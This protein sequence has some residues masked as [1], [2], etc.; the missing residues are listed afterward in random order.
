M[1]EAVVVRER[2]IIFSSEMVCAILDGRK[3]QT[4]RVINNRVYIEFTASEEPDSIV[5]GHIE[6]SDPGF[7]AAAMEHMRCPYGYPGGRLWV[8]EHFR[9]EYS[10]ETESYRLRYRGDDSVRPSD[11]FPAEWAEVQNWTANPFPA[12]HATPWKPSIHMPRWASRLTLEITEVRVQRVQEISEEDAIAE[13]VTLGHQS[14]NGPV[15]IDGN[16]ARVG[17]RRLW[18]SLNAKRGYGW[19]ANPWV[20]AIT[21]RLA[22][23]E[24]PS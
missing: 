20:W 6:Q 24:S 15:S 10:A 8:R 12:I 16:N 19:D 23:Q 1:S 11:D 13:G 14:A 21:F 3:T 9:M 18:D 5:T 2:P 17:Y 4:R 22:P 7:G